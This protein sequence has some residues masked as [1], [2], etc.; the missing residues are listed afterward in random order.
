[1]KIIYVAGP[2]RADTAWGVEQNVRRAEE[3]GLRIAHAGASPLIPHAN[4]RFFHGELSDEFWLAATMELLRRSDAIY[5]LP[6]WD[7]SLG[8]CQEY[9]EARRLGLPILRDIAD[10]R[11]WLEREETSGA[12]VL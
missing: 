6:Q 8:A 2:F 5:L 11:S 3:A 1:M 9:E 4:T 12:I 10:V 7:Q